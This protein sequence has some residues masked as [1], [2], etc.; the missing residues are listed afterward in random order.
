MSSDLLK[1]L[2]IGFGGFIGTVVRY[3]AAVFFANFSDKIVYMEQLPI[4]TLSVNL[5]G[6]FSAGLVFNLAA[7]KNS[8]SQN[9]ILFQFLLVG[10][11]GG[12]T[13]FSSLILDFYKL[14]EGGLSAL[15]VTYLSL[16]ILGGIG[17]LWMGAA[18]GRLI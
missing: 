13:T 15:G 12:L 3:F 14:V 17:L 7:F 9:S 6:A 16:S 11:L 10:I 5:V 2:I 8:A 1:I 4:A 18:V